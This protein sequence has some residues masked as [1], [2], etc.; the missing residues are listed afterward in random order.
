MTRAAA[1]L[2][3]GLPL[4]A[5]AQSP[6]AQPGLSGIGARADSATSAVITWTTDQAADAEVDYGL[7]TAY[8]GSA[9]AIGPPAESHSVVLSGLAAGALYHYRVKSRN[10]GGLLSVSGDFT[11]TA[12]V[13]PPLAPAPAVAAPLVLIMNPPQGAF[14]SG[15]VTISANATS[16]AGVAAVQFLLDG[17]DLA[18]PLASA[19][20]TFSWNTA[21]VADGGHGLA[22][23]ARDAAGR[24]ATSPIVP[25]TVDNTPPAISEVSA[26]AVS[27]SGAVIL[28]KTNERSNSQVEYGPTPAY[29]QSTPLNASLVVNRGV[30]LTGLAPDTLY[31]YRVKSRDAAGLLSVSGD[32]ILTT[33]GASGGV[34]AAA[35]AAATQGDSAAKAP[36]KTLTPALADGINDRAVFGPEAREVSIVDLHGRRVFHETSAGPAIVW[37]CRDGSGSVVPSGV[38]IASIVTRDSRRLYQSFTVAK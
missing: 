10:A 14:V 37:N 38:Y 23:V 28:W 13:P 2:L 6:P 4:L 8:G 19:P 22:A 33:T 36:Q 26:A 3:V 32:N 35:G 15:V 17:L 29:G 18:P 24:A 11:F 21:F 12:V 27:A 31:Y 25:V 9:S 20:Y 34:S 5:R 1:I 16:G 30:P 7:S